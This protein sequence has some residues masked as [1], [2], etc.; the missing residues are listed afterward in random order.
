MSWGA[1]IPVTIRDQ[2]ALEGGGAIVKFIAF[3]VNLVN[4]VRGGIETVI[5]AVPAAAKLAA[6]NVA[7]SSV[8]P[9]QER[10]ARSRPTHQVSRA[11]PFHSMLGFPW[12]L[13][14]YA[15]IVIGKPPTTPDDGAIPV[16]VG[17]L[18]VV[19]PPPPLPP[20]PPLPPEPEPP[21]PFN[22][23][24]A[25]T[26]SKKTYIRIMPHP[27]RFHGGL[28]DSIRQISCTKEALRLT[29]ISGNGV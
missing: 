10:G 18:N 5:C 12:R 3:D 20:L 21:Q 29:L 2:V 1:D 4:P 22:P 13:E 9:V 25:S 28:R 17:A 6:G 11:F 24:I 8:A 26:E 15:T 19:P 23:I 27:F 16:S 7:V 14:T